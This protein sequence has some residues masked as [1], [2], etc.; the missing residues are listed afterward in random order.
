MTISKCDGCGKEI[1]KDEEGRVW[2]GKGSSPFG[3]QEFCASC[4]K[5][6]MQFLKR[7]E[8]KRK[9]HAR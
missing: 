8:R 9:S 5:P 6:L 7:V 1:P 3:A 4:G 2:A